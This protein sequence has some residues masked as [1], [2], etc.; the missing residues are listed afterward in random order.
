MSLLELTLSQKSLHRRSVPHHPVLHKHT[1]TYTAD[2]TPILGESWTVDL[3]TQPHNQ[4]VRQLKS[5]GTCSHLEYKNFEESRDS[6]SLQLHLSSPYR[7][8]LCYMRHRLLPH[9]SAIRGHCKTRKHKDI[10]TDT[11]DVYTATIRQLVL[12]TSRE[13]LPRRHKRQATRW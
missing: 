12:H 6:S 2:K 8:S 9:P 1:D 10:F 4:V 11:S 3:K 5:C 13:H 7:L